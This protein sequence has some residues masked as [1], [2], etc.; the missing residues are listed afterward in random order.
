ML[1]PWADVF[2]A[3]HSTGIPNIE[4]YFA[5]PPEMRRMLAVGPEAG[6]VWTTATA[7]GAA[8]KALGGVAPAG[9]QTPASAFG[10]DF[11]LETEGVTREDV[12]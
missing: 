4:S 1:V 6:V 8:R 12:D 9:Y 3:W 10:A 2:T 5:A 7:L 11:V